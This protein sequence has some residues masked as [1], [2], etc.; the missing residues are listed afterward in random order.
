MTRVRLI[1]VGQFKE[2]YY[3]DAAAE[4]AKRLG[5]FCD[6]SDVYIKEEKIDDKKLTDALTERAL[7][8]EGQRIIDAAGTRSFRVAMC[9]EGK[10]YSSEALSELIE[11]AVTSYDSVCFIVGSSRGLSENVKREC[12]ARV[13]MSDMTFPHSLARVMLTEQL[14]RAFSIMNGTKYHK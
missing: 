13:S 7:E 5:A 2:P 4:Y 12:H 1:H 8:A 11:T 9:I 3:A 6:F 14:Y 10:K